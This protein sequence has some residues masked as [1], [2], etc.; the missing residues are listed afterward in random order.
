MLYRKMHQ[1]PAAHKALLQDVATMGI[2]SERREDGKLPEAEAS[3]SGEGE[4]EVAPLTPAETEAHSQAVADI[5]SSVLTSQ[6]R[7]ADAEVMGERVKDS[8]SNDVSPADTGA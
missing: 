5:L 4:S 7:V 3:S 1:Q 6:V 2:P 8:I